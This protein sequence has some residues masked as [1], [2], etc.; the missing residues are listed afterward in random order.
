MKGSKRDQSYC[1]LKYI[2]H[3]QYLTHFDIGAEQKFI[4]QIK[5]YSGVQYLIKMTSQIKGK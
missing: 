1:I 3:P 5:V 4:K 2:T